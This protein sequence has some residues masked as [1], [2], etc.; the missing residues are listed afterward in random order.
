MNIKFTY[1][2]EQIN[3]ALH[4]ARLAAIELQNNN[5]H[6]S[7]NRIYKAIALLRNA[8][9]GIKAAEALTND[10]PMSAV[11]ELMGRENAGS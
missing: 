6:I 2:S 10:D 9:R 5:T 11:I 1:I 8:Q 4:C 7:E 3:E